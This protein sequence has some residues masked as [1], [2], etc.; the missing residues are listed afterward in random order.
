M[1]TEFVSRAFLEVNGVT[2]EAKEASYKVSQEQEIVNTMNPRARGQGYV[3]GIPT[4]EL[5]LVVPLPQDGHPV[6][7]DALMLDKTLFDVKFIYDGGKARQ[8]KDCKIKDLDTPSREG[9][10]TDVTIT[11]DALDMFID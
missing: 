11:A 10:G 8:F 4:F 9:E 6:N 3:D 5:T 1:A 2:I 7:F